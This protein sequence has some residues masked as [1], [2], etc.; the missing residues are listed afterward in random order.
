MRDK[1]RGDSLRWE[2]TKKYLRAVGRDG[3]I[4]FIERS[5]ARR[6]NRQDEPDV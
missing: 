5:A 2:L 4:L 3:V 6:E 1:L